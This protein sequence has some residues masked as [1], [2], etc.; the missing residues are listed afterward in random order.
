MNASIVVP[1]LPSVLNRGNAPL[2]PGKQPRGSIFDRL[3]SDLPPV[4]FIEHAL[5]VTV[6]P[7]ARPCPLPNRLVDTIV[8]AAKL[9]GN[10]VAHRWSLF[11]IMLEKQRE[12]SAARKTG[13]QVSLVFRLLYLAAGFFPFFKACWTKL[14]MRTNI[15]CTTFPAFLSLVLRLFPVFCLPNL[16]TQPFL[17]PSIGLRFLNVM[18]KCSIALVLLV[19]P[20]WIVAQVTKTHEELALGLMDG[21][22]NSLE[23]CPG[24]HK[25]WCAGNLAG[26]VE[27]FATLTIA[28]KTGSMKHLSPRRHTS[29]PVLTTT[30]VQSN[31]G[32]PPFLVSRYTGLLQ[33]CGNI[34][35]R[36]ALV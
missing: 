14:V 17:C 16:C 15:C 2:L 1:V 34:S 3:V 7:M 35:G 24:Q 13:E 10:L 8:S 28:P 6:H 18:L 30:F 23:E 27:M 5:S 31:C 12:L 33:T 25:V 20:R 22:Y 32:K 11:Q 4:D 26:K 36:L 29:L 21:P 19:T 9:A